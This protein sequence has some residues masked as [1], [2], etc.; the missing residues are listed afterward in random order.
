M[1]ATQSVRATLLSLPPPTP[2]FKRWCGIWPTPRAAIRGLGYLTP[3]GITWSEANAISGDG[4]TIVGDGRGFEPGSESFRMARDATAMSALDEINPD[5]WSI[6]QDVNFDGSVVVGH[7][8]TRGYRWIAGEFSFLDALDSVSTP[9]IKGVSDDGST[10]V[11]WFSLS[12]VGTACVW[13]AA[14]DVR[15]LADILSREFGVDLTG[16]NLGYATDVSGDGHTI[17]GWG[18]NPFGNSEAFIAT[19]PARALRS[20]RS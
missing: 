10:V 14:G 12:G 13:D 17:V 4:S 2:T 16:W 5:G 19:I 11:G 8:R 3:G 7:T 18:T 1:A 6:A 20:R 15:P 9:I